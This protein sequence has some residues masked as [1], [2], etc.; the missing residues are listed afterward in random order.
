LLDD[1]LGEVQ[2]ALDVRR[3]ERLE[4]LD[5]IVREPLR[6]EDTGVVD[7]GVGRTFSFW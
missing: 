7:Q 5:R 4:V 6:E 2:E 3:D 1:Q